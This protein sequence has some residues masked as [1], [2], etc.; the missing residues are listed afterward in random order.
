MTLTL[1]ETAHNTGRLYASR[2]KWGILPWRWAYGHYRVPSLSLTQSW[3]APMWC[4]LGTRTPPF[5]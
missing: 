4:S 2:D 3:N 1:G 5:A